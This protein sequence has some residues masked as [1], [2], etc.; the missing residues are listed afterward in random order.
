MI[1][2]ARAQ[3]LIGT[4]FITLLQLASEVLLDAGEPHLPNDR[5]LGPTF[6]R[7]AFKAIEFERFTYNDLVTL[8]GWDIAFTRTIADLDAVQL[9]PSACLSNSDAHIRDVGRVHE[10]LRTRSDLRTIGGI[11]TRA[12]TP[13]SSW[14]NQPATLAVITGFESPAELALLRALPSVTLAAWAVR[15][16]RAAHAQRMHD[17]VGADTP[18]A[19]PQSLLAAPPTTT[20]HHLR[21]RLFEDSATTPAPIDESVTVALYAGVHEEVEAASSWVAEQILEHGVAAQDI[22]I[23]SAIA[24][25]YG[26]LLRARLAALPWAEP[27]TVTF[28]E[29]GIPL[30][31]RADGA[32]LL[33]AIRA[34]QRG[35][36]RDSLA[37]LLPLLRPSDEN[38]RVR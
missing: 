13:A 1:E 4:R 32:R 12:V 31:E 28:S 14:K 6:V 30:T 2:T 37:P 27:S 8:P 18:H 22:A 34:L 9:S 38:C 24:E 16:K 3:T 26:S 19:D 33:L 11:L 25:P 5:E 35:L 23:F 20:L 10:I 7:E 15:P 29:R 36:S 21:I 17:L